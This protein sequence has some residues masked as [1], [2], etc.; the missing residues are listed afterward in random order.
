MVNPWTLPRCRTS[1]Q[2]ETHAQ[3]ITHCGTPFAPLAFSNTWLKPFRE[4]GFCEHEIPLLLMWLRDNK[5]C[6]SFAGFPLRRERTHLF[7]ATRPYL[8]FCASLP[9]FQSG[10]TEVPVSRG[11]SGLAGHPTGRS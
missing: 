9:H 11:C 4:F 8:L 7:P 5:R 3:P 10:E 6:L 2:S 1:S